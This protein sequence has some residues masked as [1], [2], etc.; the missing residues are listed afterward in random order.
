LR[1]S[2]TSTRTALGMLRIL[3]IF[4]PERRNHPA[5]G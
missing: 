5:R 1:L 4:I 3:R 2:L